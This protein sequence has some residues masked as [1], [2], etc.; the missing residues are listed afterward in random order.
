MTSSSHN[1]N[2][3]ERPKARGLFPRIYQFFRPSYGSLT[4]SLS[5]TRIEL[6]DFLKLL[7]FPALVIK[8]RLKIVKSFYRF[9]RSQ[10]V[11][12]KGRKLDVNEPR[13]I[14]LLVLCTEKDLATLPFALRSCEQFSLNPITGCSVVAPSAC[15]S[16]I[17]NLLSDFAFSFPVHVL[18]ENSF[19]DELLLSRIRSILKDNSGHAIQQL[20]KFGYVSLSSAEGVLVLDSDTIL[21][22]P[23]L[24]L[25][26]HGRQL[27]Q[28]AWEY[29]PEHYEHLEQLCH[30]KFDNSFNTVTH[31]MLI[32]PHLLRSMSG[33]KDSTDLYSYQNSAFDLANHSLQSI[34]S[35][36][37]LYYGLNLIYSFPDRVFFSRWCN[38]AAKPLESSEA[39]SSLL[40]ISGDIPYNSISFHAWQN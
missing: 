35:L 23:Q 21:L 26:L 18:S 20:V 40:E 25:D 30:K 3:K 13:D 4:E 6:G 14:E 8:H 19:I 10:L 11:P 33:I 28:L 38:K 2:A 12:F 34:F 39:Y 16:M 29:I 7:W 32:Q 9:C 17:E 22:K 37:Y 5:K 27:L 1:T 31:H 15:I 24:W 36:D